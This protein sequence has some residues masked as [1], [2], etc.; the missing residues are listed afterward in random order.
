M[1]NQSFSKL[2]EGENPLKIDKDLVEIQK[3]IIFYGDKIILNLEKIRELL[4]SAF[5]NKKN[6]ETMIRPQDPLLPLLKNMKIPK[7]YKN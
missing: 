3:T 6:N 4:E 5:P 2:K 1:N 7:G